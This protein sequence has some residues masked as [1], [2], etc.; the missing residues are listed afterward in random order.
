MPAALVLPCGKMPGRID[1]NSFRSSE[2]Y[3]MRTEMELEYFI[4][5]VIFL[6]VILKC[7]QNQHHNHNGKD[8]FT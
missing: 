3:F 6:L 8:G 4:C 2:K 5:S 7:F 1:H